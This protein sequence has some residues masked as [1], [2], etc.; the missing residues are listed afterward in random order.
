MRGY[1]P[2]SR[3]DPTQPTNANRRA[4][5]QTSLCQAAAA[6]PE[7]RQCE[8][9][10]AGAEIDGWPTKTQKEPKCSISHC[11]RTWSI[12]G[13]IDTRRK[14]KR[15]KSVSPNLRGKY[16]VSMSWLRTTKIDCFS[17]ERRE[18]KVEAYWG[19]RIG[20]SRIAVPARRLLLDKYAEGR[21]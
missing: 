15:S 20:W 19:E 2:L 18:R 9:G 3:G 4:S 5:L 6:F 10:Q 17:S 7:V 8:C 12:K 11:E 21:F 16:T 13:P 1:I 14:A